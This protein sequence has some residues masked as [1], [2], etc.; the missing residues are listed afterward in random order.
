MATYQLRCLSNP[1]ILRAILPQRLLTFLDPFREFFRARGCALPRA[2][3]AVEI[4][5]PA[6]INVFMSPDASTPRDLLDG[7]FLVDEMSTPEGMD[8]LLETAAAENLH[9]D[10]G[11]EDTPADIAVQVWLLDRD[12]L[13]RK[14][15]EQFLFKPKSFEY[16][17][18]KCDEPPLFALPTV[19]TR[20]SLERELDHWFDEKK[21]GRGSRV[22][23]YPEDDE[24]WFLVR[25]GEPFKR[26]ESLLGNDVSSVCYRPLKY[27]V[28][29]YDRRLGELRI[30]ARLVGERK[31]YRQKLGKYLFGDEDCFPGT[32]KYTLDPLR[33]LGADS[34]ACGDVDGIEWIALAEVDLLWG[35]AYREIEIRKADDVFAALAARQRELPEHPR[36]IKAVLQVKFADS[37]APRSVRLRPSNVAEYTRDSDAALVEQWLNLRGFIN[38]EEATEDEAVAE[39]VAGA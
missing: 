35:G 8:V 20:R 24:V 37:R 17:Q 30:G 5:Y 6:L 22:F 39:T 16:Y 18:A 14:H 19:A 13:E 38:R 4:D 9:L 25:H 15:A 28:V 3:P 26:E 31:L 12:I 2:E 23:V 11:S 34:L 29:V 32:K 36:I 21:R 7:L 1:L 27:D 10:R 33:E